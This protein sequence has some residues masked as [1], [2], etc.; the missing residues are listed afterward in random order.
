VS[1]ATEGKTVLGDLDSIKASAVAMGGQYL[2]LKQFRWFGSW[3]DDSPIPDG[4]FSP[5]ETTR[6]RHASREERTAVMNREM[7]K[8]DGVIRFPNASYDVGVIRKEDGTFR[9]RWDWYDSRLHHIMGNKDGSVFMQRYAIEL[10][11]RGYQKRGRRIVGETKRA[12]GTI[13]LLVAG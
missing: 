2:D 8:C 10:A 1:H 3:M 7:G 11:R 12:D 5:E 13:A 4:M 6:L 9:L